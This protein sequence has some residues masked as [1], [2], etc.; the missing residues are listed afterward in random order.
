MSFS[1]ES[2]NGRHEPL[3]Q[4][5]AGARHAPGTLTGWET[6]V[7]QCLH[8]RTFAAELARMNI[9]SGAI[10]TTCDQVIKR[11]LRL[12]PDGI[13]RYVDVGCGTGPFERGLIRS[14]KLAADG[15]VIAVEP[16]PSF[17][18]FTARTVRDDRVQ[19]YQAYGQDLP[20]ITER[21]FGPGKK[22]QVATVTTPMSKWTEEKQVELFRA[23]DDSTEEGGLVVLAIFNRIRGIFET[24][25]HQ[26]PTVTEIKG[27]RLPP[28]PYVVQ[29][30]RKGTQ[31]ATSLA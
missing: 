14:G 26:K 20:E 27:Q 18:R 10:A 7:E 5:P 28:W 16:N 11:I 22:A 24:V 19:V 4:R 29:S 25:F 31:Q 17:A 1:T 12:M 23:I 21:V 3:P 9:Q 8:V 30:V 2:P 6:L 15:K 13:E